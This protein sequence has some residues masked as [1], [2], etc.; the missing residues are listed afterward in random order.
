MRSIRVL[1]AVLFILQLVSFGRAD[2]PKLI[3]YQ[4]R[5]TNNLGEPLDTTVSI[6]FT[7][8]DDSTGG[9]VKWMET[10]TLV[11]V[12]EGLFNV[13]LGTNVPIDDNVFNSID[14]YL[15]IQVGADPEIEPRK[16]LISVPYAYHSLRSD[17]TGH[18]ASSVIDHGEVG[19]LTDDD[20]SQYFLVNGVR[21][22]AGDLNAGGNKITNVSAGMDPL[23][24][25]TYQQVV[26]NGDPAGG[27][28]GGMYPNPYIAADAISSTQ[29]MDNSII[30]NDLSNNSVSTDKL[31]GMA[32]T[33]DKIAWSS[34]TTNKIQNDAVTNAKIAMDAVTSLELSTG[35]VASDEIADGTI[36][37]SDLGASARTAVGITELFGSTSST[38]PATLD[39]FTIN[40]PAAGVLLITVTGQFYFDLDATSSTSVMG[41]G[42]LG[43]CNS[44]DSNADCDNTW[45]SR[46]Y[47]DADDATDNSHTEQFTIQRTFAVG[48]AGSYTFYLN[49]QATPTGATLH[50]W[51][52]ATASAI[53]VQSS[54]SVTSPISADLQSEQEQE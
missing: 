8:Y 26:K 10:H 16:R 23:D 5:L 40:T 13:I 25:V 31:V 39:Q 17:S 4:G 46:Y 24:A 28:L 7:I 43:L 30:T 38:T 12:T 18:V 6:E 45:V 1:T 44:S 52:N 20:H 32:V 22:M 9:T 42:Y 50:L 2:V 34:V 37:V 15:G 36:G 35:A 48:M 29:I 14:R 21:M 27:G 49:G 54:L 33:E 19:G 51:G 47:Q 41:A 11:S 3:N 53:F